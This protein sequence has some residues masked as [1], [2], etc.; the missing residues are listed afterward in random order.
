MGGKK[1][2][3]KPPLKRESKYKI[4][5]QWNCP[6][7]MNKNTVTVKF[8][9][10]GVTRVGQVAC[11][12]KDCASQKQHYV[13]EVLPLEAQVDVFHMFYNQI[14]N[15]GADQVVEPLHVFQQ[16]VDGLEDVANVIDF[17][18]DGFEEEAEYD[19]DG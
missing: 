11:R 19:D 5:V 10:S 3:S 9:R 17:Q 2:T 13:Y 7:C 1:K 8:I 16:A 4:P 12:G 14:I 15:Q 18:D 6:I